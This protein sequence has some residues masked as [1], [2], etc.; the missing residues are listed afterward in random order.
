MRITRPEPD[1]YAPYYATYINEVTDDCALVALER[2]RDSTASFLAGVPE[3]RG[4]HRYAPGKWT[5]R[6]VVGHV[7]DGERIFS[8]RLLRFARNDQTPLP[9]FDENLYVP[10][11]RFEKRS[12]ADVCRELTAVRDAT[13]ALV[14]SLD[15]ETML[16]RGT[17]SGKVMSVRALAWVMAGHEA[18]HIRVLGE[19]YLK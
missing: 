9:S 3:A 18:H 2:Q 11:G 7:A 1:E 10:E 12:L 16:R 17:A 5:F 14:R 6:E 4:G 13:L 8:I 19:R 15:E